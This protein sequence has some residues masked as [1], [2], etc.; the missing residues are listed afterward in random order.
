MLTA[1]TAEISLGF[2]QMFQRLLTFLQSKG[3]TAIE[4]HITQKSYSE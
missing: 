1:D 2:A 4:Y 3:M